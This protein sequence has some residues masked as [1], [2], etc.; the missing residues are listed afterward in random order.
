MNEIDVS[1]SSI[2]G[3]FVGRDDNTVN[4]IINIDKH[5]LYL[6]NLYKKYEEEKRDNKEFKKICDDLNYYT[7]KIDGDVLGLEA[8]L[9]AGNM[10][11]K[12]HFAKTCKERY[13]K[14]LIKM[15]Q[16]S[17]IA[18]DV[19]IYILSKIEGVFMLEIYHLVCNGFGEEHID[20]MIQEKIINPITK[21]LG[22]NSLGY[23]YTDILG[24]IYFLTG[25]CHIKWSK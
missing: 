17:Q 23:T 2:G 6:E 18:Q 1:D 13:H 7:S 15:T 14:K 16:F 8:K 12:L 25:N 11:N 4:N 22:I 9:E 10:T 19:N 24:M 5:S 3:K 20:S 21:E